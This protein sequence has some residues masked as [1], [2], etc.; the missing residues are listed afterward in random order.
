MSEKREAG[1]YRLGTEAKN[2]KRKLR[3]VWKKRVSM[4]SYWTGL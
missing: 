2:T 3:C 4:G 1:P